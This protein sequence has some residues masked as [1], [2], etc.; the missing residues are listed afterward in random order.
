LEY[1][2]RWHRRGDRDAAGFEALIPV[3]ERNALAERSYVD[4][5]CPIVEEIALVSLFADAHVAQ[6]ERFVM[7]ASDE[8][9]GRIAVPGGDTDVTAKLEP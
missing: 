4:R 3:Q 2:W 1:S 8:K 9:A 6:L 5:L 7:T